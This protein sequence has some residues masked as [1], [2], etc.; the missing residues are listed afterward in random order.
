MHEGRGRTSARPRRCTAGR[1][2]HAEVERLVERPDHTSAAAHAAGA[3]RTWRRAACPA[4][5]PRSRPCAGAAASGSGAALRLGSPP[6]VELGRPLAHPLPAVRALGHVRADLGPAVLADDEEVRLRHAP[7]G[8]PA[9]G[10]RLLTRQRRRRARARWRRRSRAPPRAGRGWPRRPPTWRE[11]P[12]PFSSMS[13]STRAR[14]AE[15]SSSACGRSRSISR[16]ARSGHRHAVGARAGRRACR[17]GRAARPATCSRRASRTGSA[18]ASCPPR[19]ARH[20]S[21]TIAC[22]SAARPSVCSTRVW[23]SIT[24]ISTVPKLG[25]GRTSYQR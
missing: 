24:R 10:D 13:S 15:P 6:A 25:C 22:T 1:R 7:S 14:R 23:E 21:L 5:C 4:R 16:R 17:R 12:L 3:A 20:S 2:R 9:A 8:Y 11:A 18:R 19:S